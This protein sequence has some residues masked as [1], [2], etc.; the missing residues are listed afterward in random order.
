M[1][2]IKSVGCGVLEVGRGEGPVGCGVVGRRVGGVDGRSVGSAAVITI[3]A[4]F[5]PAAKRAILS[6]RVI[7]RALI[8]P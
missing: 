8:R 1:I 3:S 2:R 7:P 4:K 5:K 6:L